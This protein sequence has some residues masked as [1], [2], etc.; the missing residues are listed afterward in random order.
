MPNP[1]TLLLYLKDS[2]ANYLQEFDGMVISNGPDFV[3]LDQTTFYPEGGGQP[4]DTG[5][6]RWTGGESRVLR[7]KKE[8]GVV[9]HFVDRMPEAPE[10]HG[11]IDWERRYAH[12]RMHSSQHLLS[13][14]V[15]NLYKAR[16]MGNQ[17]HED[18]SRVDFAPAN[19]TEADLHRIQGECNRII[20]EMTPISIYEEGRSEL[21][22][23][24]AEERAVLSMIPASI[25]KLRVIQIGDY[26]LC[27]CGGTHLRN[28][29]EIGEIQIT[30]RKSKG[31]DTDRV[32]YKLN[33]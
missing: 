9:K 33:P 28:T 14:V 26:D 29:S 32:A 25:R 2:E 17:I 30:E 22:A 20:S 6:L 13:G 5:V 18:F 15:W 31:R 3:V 27:P 21:E 4:W 24:I 8:G 1:M 7:V 23:K 16:T 11:V 10:V 19:F 12:M